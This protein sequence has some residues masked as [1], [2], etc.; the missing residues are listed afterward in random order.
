MRRLLKIAW[1]EYLAYVRTRGF[2]FSLL[3]LPVGISMI[4]VAPMVTSRSTPTPTVAIIDLTARNLTGPITQALAVR[5]DGARPV[6]LVVPAPGA[7]YPGRDAATAALRPYL[8]GP[9]I[10]PGGGLLD[11]AA[12]I[13][14]SGDGVTVDFWSR[15]VASGPVQIAIGDA[16]KSAVRNQR[17]QASGVDPAALKAID[18]FTPGSRAFSPKA[19]KGAVALK[20]QLPGFTGAAIGYLLWM[21]V[22]TGAGMLLNSVIEEKN[23][24]ILEVLLTSAS[25]P[26]IMGGKILGVAAVTGTILTF[27][28]T[29]ATIL[30][31]ITSP[32]VTADVAGFLLGHGRWAYFAIYLVGGYLMFA[33]FYVT[34]GAFCETPRE[35][36]TLQGPLMIIMSIPLMFMSLAFTHPDAT[37]LHVLTWIPLFT[38]FVMAAR[39]GADPP[40]WEI[41]AT[42]TLM[43]SVTALEL[44]VAVPAFRSGA[45]ATG[46]FELKTFFRTLAR[47]GG[48]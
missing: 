40:L 3:M 9:R 17:L 11:V 27:W 28:M 22:L 1:R 32:V 38:P 29:I 44:W 15:D 4:V 35:T 25:V 42:S 48:G 8:T 45:L 36:Q 43:F 20:D 41:I 2:W 10:L 21:V 18:A 33:T 23:S 13:W 14:P 19:E 30:L 6:G 31:A 5:A 37:I 16:V 26:E 34:L 46:R 7:P 47:R 12:I 39:A 24:R